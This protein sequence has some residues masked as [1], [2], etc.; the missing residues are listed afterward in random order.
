M[1][2]AS[3]MFHVGVLVIFFGHLSGPADADL[4]T[5]VHEALAPNR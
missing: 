1:V 5:T 4:S 3:V 2:W